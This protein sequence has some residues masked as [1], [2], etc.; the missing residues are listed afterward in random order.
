MMNGV[1][2]SDPAQADTALDV[3]IAGYPVDHTVFR[4]QLGLILP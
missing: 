1:D 2:M 4:I 3:S